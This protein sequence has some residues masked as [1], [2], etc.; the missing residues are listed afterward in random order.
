[1][2]LSRGFEFKSI[3]R[4]EANEPEYMTIRSIFFEIHL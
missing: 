1:M 3:D 2:E 4:D